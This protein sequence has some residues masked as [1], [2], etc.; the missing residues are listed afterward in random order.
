MYPLALDAFPE[1]LAVE[2]EAGAL[3]LVERPVPGADHAPFERSLEAT[4]EDHGVR[5]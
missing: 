1:D 3:R 2:G 5:Q 4:I